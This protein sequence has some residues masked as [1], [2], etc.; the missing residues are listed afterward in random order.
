VMYGAIHFYKAC[1]AA[2]VKPIL[3]C[4][5]YV[6]PRRLEDREGR[7][8]RDPYHLTVLAADAQG[9]RNLMALCSIGHLKGLYYKPRIDREVLAA[10]SKGLIVLSGCLGG[11][12]ATKV[13]NGDS[14]AARQTVADYRDI[15]G[16][17]RYLLEVQRHGLDAQQRVNEALGGFARE[18]G[19]RQ[20][21]T[22]D[23]HY[24]HQQDAEAHDV[25]LC[26]Q[27]G[28]NFDDP[29][30]WRF[31]SQDFYLKTAAEMGDLF[32]DLPQA[33]A[34]TL[35]V[36]D[37][38]N[39]EIDLGQHLLPPFQCPDGLGPD[40]YLER[41][42]G[43]G[44]RWRYG[45]EPPV[46]ASERAA[47]E[48]EVIRQT[49]FSSYFLIVWDFYKFARSSG[50][51]TGP[52]RGSAAGSLVA[53]CLG[54]TDLDPLAH[55]LLFERFLNKDRV[56]MPDIDCDFSVEGRER[57]IRYVTDKYGS[58]R[59]AQI[60]TFTTMASKAAIRDVGRVLD[61]PLR[62]T[63]RLAKSVPVFQGR[64]K[65]LEDAVKE[66]PE[67]RAAYESDPQT[68]PDG[69]RYDL[70]RLVEVARSLEGVSRN[71]S[72]HAAGVVIAPEP[73][74]HFAPLQ[75]GP[76][77]ESV[78]TQYDMK[79]VQEIGLL[80]M[81]FLGLQNLDIISTCLSLIAGRHGA[82]PD[83]EKVGFDDPR[84]YELISTADTGGVFQLDGSGMRRMLQ[85][86]RPQS[87]EDV[88]AA[89]A[90]FRPG[91]MQNIPAY[92]ARKQGREKIEYMHERLE[93]ILRE[94]YGV[95]IYQEQVM[96]AARELAGFT[97][98]EADILRAAM[99]KKDRVKM[100]QQ[101]QKFVL[102]CGTQGI[103]EPKAEELF[104]AI[105]RFAGY[106]F[107]RAHAAAYAVIS[108]RTAYLKANH[109]IEYMTSLLIHQ[110]GSADKIS[111]TIVDCKRRGIDV[112]APAINTSQA[113]F[114][115]VDG[116]VLFGL[117]AIRNVG[118]GGAEQ[119]VLERRERG[120]FRSL[121]DLCERGTGLQDVNARALD[122]LVRCGACDELGER[123]QLLASLDSARQ[124]AERAR[125]DRLAGQTSFFEL[126]PP[127]IEEAVPMPGEEKLRNEKEL[128]G[129]YLSDHP[130]NRIEVELARLT[131]TSASQVT[132]DL[133]GTEVRVGGLVRDVRR[134]V[135]RKGQIMAYAELE[136][137]TGTIE[138]TLFPRSYEQLR[139]LFERAQ[140]DAKAIV[141]QGKV[142]AA[143]AGGRAAPP[144]LD[145]EAALD[146]ESE[147]AGVIADLAW[148]WDDPECA[149]VERRH[150]AHVEVPEGADEAVVE[151][152]ATLLGGHPGEDDVHVHLKVGGSRVSLAV[153]E[154]FRVTCGAALKADL[155]SLFARDVTRFE[156]VRP[157]AATG[158]NG[159]SDGNGRAR[160]RAG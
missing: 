4:E 137:L 120:P 71:V 6:A 111:A 144:P 52:G 128:L 22:N 11:E 121:D 86:M 138:V 37:Q 81:D 45:A 113:D 79:A 146:E 66:V 141:V 123:N 134:V 36:A 55:G 68:G 27:T 8:D 67:F 25:L 153:G 133:A 96:M 32:S 160:H 14:E 26:L 39:L 85:E 149:P 136:D 106:G 156:A 83:L 38:V 118:R 24:V 46:A 116:Q 124:R 29:K 77:R 59:V 84:T 35:E 34:S 23:L 44:V 157:R 122:A 70:H 154:R 58:D 42:V 117:A 135:T 48:L 80:K 74:V 50:V 60:V 98:S 145:D 49:G 103:P 107:P 13:T 112:Q 61:V 114:S 158:G 7:T 140:L 89:V 88:T 41:L 99:G 151:R 9:Y 75:F 10:H 126:V 62:E 51:V 54:I 18:F 17:D 1:R 33:L 147:R 40:A 148:V 132:T 82:A 110:Q 97:L 16:P 125:Q 73:L 127:P 90:L 129:L 65:S 105:N 43:E 100:A 20:V 76:G 93:P 131:D 57:V 130:L 142:E 152:L 108:Y 91:P 143:R 104:E 53:Y 95:M 150:T 101:R 64:S 63:D 56:S 30:R 109:P 19:L 94:T 5:V 159:R 72:T 31:D 102:G 155:D 2:G 21:A 3:G 92:V 15:F 87:F 119:L 115:I 28:A 78:I 47:T 69:R 139:P 12:V